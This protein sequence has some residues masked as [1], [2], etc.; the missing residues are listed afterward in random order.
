DSYTEDAIPYEEDSLK[1]GSDTDLRKG[2]LER[3]KDWEA[4][5]KDEVF[6]I[7]DEGNE[8]LA[9]KN[10]SEANDDFSAMITDYQEKA[11]ER[12]ERVQDKE[13]QVLAY[14]KQ[15]QVIELVAT[16]LAILLGIIIAYVT[17]SSISKP[18]HHLM[19][20]MKLIASGDLSAK[21]LEVR[22]S[23]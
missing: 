15:S 21:S 2:L 11:K 7:Y 20:R 4:F 22:T 13:A 23:D 14:T 16:I 3:A 12:Q 17:S 10:V 8:N 9:I 18:V 5:I 6:A 1:L 19:E